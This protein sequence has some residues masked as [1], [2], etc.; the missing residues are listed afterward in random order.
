LELIDRIVTYFQRN[1][2]PVSDVNDLFF[3][4][5]SQLDTTERKASLNT[6]EIKYLQKLAQSHFEFMYGDA[7]NVG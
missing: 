6:E 5:P 3:K 4:L 7:H 2:V 1:A